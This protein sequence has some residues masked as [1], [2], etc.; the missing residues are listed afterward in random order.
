M[1]T[2]QHKATSCTINPEGAWVEELTM[3]SQPVL[4]PKTELTNENGERKA[5]GGMHV[6]LPNFGPGGDSGLPQHGFGRTMT[7]DVTRHTKTSAKLRLKNPTPRYAGLVA[8]LE[9]ELEET[10]LSSTLSLRNAGKTAVRVA[11][12][13]HP[14]FYLDESEKAVSINSEVYEL[15][16]LAG[17][18]YITADSVALSTA[19]RQVNITQTGLP[20]WAI[21]TDGLAE[22]ICVEPTYGGNRFLETPAPDEHLAPGAEKVFSCTIHW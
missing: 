18:E 15:A 3:Q 14:Y 8:T 22:Y 6:C 4:F 5:R 12:G 17:T 11:P 1:L 21:W 9:Y 2:L 20:V 10:A 16:N 13:F 7:W 19:D